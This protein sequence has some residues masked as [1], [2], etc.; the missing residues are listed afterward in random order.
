MKARYTSV[1]ADVGSAEEH[2]SE[3]IDIASIHDMPVIAA[4][5]H[6][7]VPAVACAFKRDVPKARLAYVMTDGAALPLA[8]SDLVDALR[9]RGLLDV[10]ITSGHAFGGDYEAVTVHSALAVARHVA[11]ADVAVVAM[12][13]GIVGTNTRLGFTGMEVGSVLDAAAGLHGDPIACVRASFADPRP[14]HQGVS[15]H[16]RTALSVGCRSRVSI[17]LPAVG[18]SEEQWLRADLHDAGLDDRHDVIAVDPGDVLALFAEH[19][20]AVESMGRAATD[21]PILY[22][23][24]AAAG[25]L[26]AG[27]L[28]H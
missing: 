26:A 2:A 21:D 8:L 23:C 28:R 27:R 10:T 25:R 7:Q 20:L 22:A 13:P 1:Q 19:G 16:T 15:H 18:G 17:A 12:G 6:S 11:R 5:L 9:S 24:G 3:L 14:R 4:A